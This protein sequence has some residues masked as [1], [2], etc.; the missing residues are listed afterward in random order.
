M[1]NENRIIIK[2]KRGPFINMG[3]RIYIEFTYPSKDS[4]ESI[5]KLFDEILVPYYGPPSGNKNQ[6]IPYFID[7]KGNQINKNTGIIGGCYIPLQLM[8][9]LLERFIEV[10]KAIIEIDDKTFKDK[11]E[12]KK[13]LSAIE[14]IK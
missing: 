10:D 14:N 11:Y 1:S 3:E 4:H 2:M 12:E 9:K 7:E 5:F 8:G 13:I 6:M